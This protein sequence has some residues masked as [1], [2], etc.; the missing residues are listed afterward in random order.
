L[1]YYEKHRLK[2][3][4]EDI[5]STASEKP[6][7]KIGEDR[8]PRGHPLSKL[9]NLPKLLG[10]VGGRLLALPLLGSAIELLLSLAAWT[11]RR[12]RLGWPLLY[13]PKDYDERESWPLLLFLHG[14][15]ERGDDLQLVKKHGLPQLIE[16]GQQFPFIVVSPQCPKHQWWRPFELAA[17]LDVIV[18]TYKVDED[19]IYVT[20]MSMGGFGAWSLAAYTP[21]RFAA[22][23]PICGGGSVLQAKRMAHIPTWVFH[24]AED[25]NV[26]LGRSQKMVGALKGNGDNVRFTIY[27]KTGHDS[28]TETYATPQLYEWLLQQK[29]SPR[30]PAGDAA[31]AAERAPNV[32]GLKPPQFG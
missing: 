12:K 26:P 19:R 15:G 29:R 9:G 11:L 14:A 13:L 23:V 10:V 7:E 32:A 4:S 21:W 22:V 31:K 1:G 18:A 27:P 5:I 16:A 17:L 6:D 25:P 3:W 8:S 24:G 28:W 2:W 30:V 20:G